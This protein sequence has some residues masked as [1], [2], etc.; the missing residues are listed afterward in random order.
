MRLSTLA[1]LAVLALPTAVSTARN[2][3]P[4]QQKG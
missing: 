4:N 1:L 2:P 3:T